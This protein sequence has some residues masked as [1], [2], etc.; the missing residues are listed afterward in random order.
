MALT[1]HTQ[2]APSLKKE[3]IYISTAH[4]GRRGHFWGLRHLLSLR[5]KPVYVHTIRF[6]FPYYIELCRRRNIILLITSAV[7]EVP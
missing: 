4:L 2:L 1:T 7:P 3:Y 6:P 5:F